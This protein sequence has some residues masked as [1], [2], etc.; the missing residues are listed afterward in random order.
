MSDTATT[1]HFS[2]VDLNGDRADLQASYYMGPHFVGPAGWTESGYRYIHAHQFYQARIALDGGIQ[3]ILITPDRSPDQLGGL[4][5]DWRIGFHSTDTETGSLLFDR[6]H[7]AFGEALAVPQE[8]DAYVHLNGQTTTLLVRASTVPVERDGQTIHALKVEALGADGQP[9]AVDSPLMEELLRNGIGVEYREDTTP[10]PHDIS[11]RMGVAVSGDGVNYTGAVE[12]QAG[13]V[14]AIFRDSATAPI[15]V[16]FDGDSIL[17]EFFQGDRLNTDFG[18]PEA[19][20]FSVLI[21][22]EQSVTVTQVSQSGRGLLLKTAA[23][24]DAGS[25]VQVIYSDDQGDQVFG[26]L[27]T[28]IGND[29]PSSSWTATH[30]PNALRLVPNLVTGTAASE[31]L[32]GTDGNDRIAPAGGDDTIDGG[33]GFDLVV[34][35]G[36][37]SSAQLVFG[38]AGV[39]LTQG[40]QTYLFSNVEAVAFDDVT[41]AQFDGHSY[42]LFPYGSSYESAKLRA[43]SLGGHLLT[44]GTAAENDFVTDLMITSLVNSVALGASDASDE[45][46]W[47]WDTGELV[48]YN[49][50]GPGQPDDAGGDQDFASMI[51]GGSLQG[52]EDRSGWDDRGWGG[53]LLIEVGSHQLITG[54]ISG[55]DGPD[56]L[57]LPNGGSIAQGL[58]GDDQITGGDGPDL[59]YGDAGNDALSGGLGDDTLHGGLDADSLDGG[60]GQD[61]LRGGDG[62]DQVAGGSGHDRIWGDGGADSLLGGDGDDWIDAGPGQDSVDAG[63]GNDAVLIGGDRDGE[64]DTADGGE[65]YD[66]A[67]YDYG[68]STQGVTFKVS[69]TNQQ[70]DPAGGIDTLLNFEERK[71]WGTQHGDSL[72]GSIRRDNLHGRDGDDTI[73]GLGGNDYISGDG[74]SDSLSGGDGDDFITAGRQ[75]DSGNDTVDGGAG[76][77][78]VEY[79]YWGWSTP[80]DFVSNWNASGNFTQ[81]DPGGGVDTLTGIEEVQVV[82]SVVNDLIVGDA[83]RNRIMGNMGDDTLTGG[84]GED[85]FGYSLGFDRGMDVITD[86][87]YGD[88]IRLWDG[89]LFS[90]A[91][92][93]SAGDLGLGQAV[94]SF[95]DAGVLISFGVDEQPGADL[96]I[97]LDR[98]AAED[99]TVHLRQDWNHTVITVE[100]N[101]YQAPIFEFNYHGDRFTVELSGLVGYTLSSQ[102][103]SRFLTAA[104]VFKSSS[105]GDAQLRVIDLETGTVLAGRALTPGEFLVPSSDADTL[106]HVGQVNGSTLRIDSYDYG[107]AASDASLLAAPLKTVTLSLPT[108]AA[109]F[110]IDQYIPPQDVD[111]AGFLSARNTQLPGSGRSLFRIDASGQTTLLENPPDAS[112]AWIGNAFVLNEELWVSAHQKNQDSYYRLTADGWVLITDHD[113]FWDA[114]DFAIQIKSVV[115]DGAGALDLIALLPKGQVA[116]V[117][118]EDRVERLPDG[119]LL[120]RVKAYGYGPGGVEYELWAVK[121]GDDV[122]YKDFT[123]GPGGWGLLRS[124]RDFEPEFVYFQQLNLTFDE[125]GLPVQPD[126]ALT[127]HRIAVSDIKSALMDASDET[128]LS[129]LADAKGVALLMTVMRSSFLIEA[130]LTFLSG[131]FSPSLFEM[132][133]AGALVFFGDYDAT[134]DEATYVINRIDSEGNVTLATVVPDG[135]FEDVVVD[136][137]HGLFFR[138][139]PTDEIEALAYH[140]NPVS[141]VLS[142][143]SVPLFEAIAAAGGIPSDVSFLSGTDANDARGDP[144]AAGTTPQWIAG[145]GGSDTLAGGRGDDL[146]HGGPGHDL[147]DGGKGNDTLVGNAGDDTLRG[148]LGNDRL[149]GDSGS[150]L[151]DGGEQRR[152][153]WL[154]GTA[155]DNDRLEYGDTE[156]IFVNLYTRTV[157][158]TGEQGTDTYS[159]I[160]EITGAFNRRDTIIGRLTN[161]VADVEFGSSLYL[162]LQGGSDTVVQDGYGYQQNWADGV[163]VDYYWSQTGID[164]DYVGDSATV[165]YGASGAQLSGQDTL[166]RV[167]IIG[168]TAH[169]DH[170]NLSEATINHRGHVVDPVMGSSWHALLLGR[171]GNDTVVGNDWTFLHFGS[172]DHTH[173]G[174]GLWLDL[175]EGMADLSNLSTNGI[176]LGTVTFSGVRGTIG[177]RFDDT[178]IGG[179]A[180]N[181]SFESFRGDGGDDFIDGGSGFD[182]ASY[183]WSADGVNVQ[184]AAGIVSSTSSGSDTLRSIENVQGSMFA[185]VYDARG[186]WGGGTSTTANVGSFGSGFNEFQPEGGDDLIHGN[187]RTRLDYDSVMVAVRVDLREGVADARLEADKVTEAYLTMG[188]DAFHGVNEVHGTAYDDL[189]LGGDL[190]NG[191]FITDGYEGFR[192]NAGHDTIDGGTGFDTAYYDNSPAAVQVTLGGL[193]DGLAYD[194][195]GFVDVLREIQEVVGSHFADR[196]NGSNDNVFESLEGRGGDD[197]LNGGLGTTRASYI[198]SPAGA[199]V[200]LAAGTAQDG[201]GSTDTLSGIEWVRGSEY[202]DSISGSDAERVEVFEPRGGND[203]VDGRGGIDQIRYNHASSAVQVDLH[204]GTASDGTGS[205]DSLISIENANA[206]RFDD[207]LRG[208]VAANLL[209]G[210]S[211]NDTLEGRSGNDTLHGGDGIDTAVFTGPRSSY[212]L[213]REASGAW[214]VVDNVAERDGTDTLIGVEVA[215][216]SDGLYGLKQDGGVQFA[217]KFFKV[218]PSGTWLADAPADPTPVPTQV[219]LSQVEATAGTIVTLSR[220]GDFQYGFGDDPQGAPFTDTGTPLLARF[221]NANGQPVQPSTFLGHNTSTQSSGLET[222]VSEDFF[223][224]AGV[225]QIEVP[226]G[227]T[228]LQFSV[229]DRFF[230]D[231]HDPDNDFG[232]VIRKAD[233]YSDYSASDL[234]FGTP[235]AD[236]LIGGLGNDS[237]AGGPGDDTLVGNAGDDRFWGGPGSDVLDGG[238]QKRVP[239]QVSTA[240]DYDRLDY[241]GTAGITVDLAARTVSVTEEEGL[242]LFTGIEEIHGAFNGSDTI[243]GR[244]TASVADAAD[245]TA[246]YLYL[247]GGSDT[248]DQTGYGAQQPW[249]D[250]VIVAYHWSTTPINLVYDGDTATV[251]YGA[252]GSQSAGV[253]TLVNVGVV[254]DS[255]KDDRFDFSQAITNQAGYATS[256]YHQASWH[257]VLMGRGGSDTVIG[258]GLTNLHFGAVDRSA[259]GRGVVLDLKLGDADLS[260]LSSGGNPLGTVT[261]TGVRGFTGTRFNDTLIGGNADNNGFESFRGDGGDDFIDGGQGFDRASYRWS[262]DA[263]TVDLA[264]GTVSSVSSGHDTLRSIEQIQGSMFDDWID[265]RGFGDADAMN[266]G[267]FW[268]GFNSILP[269]GGNDTVHGNGATQLD[270]EG[271]MVGVHAD[272]SAGFGDALDPQV[273]SSLQ[274]GTL[275]RVTFSGVYSLRGSSNDDWLVGGGPGR[276][277]SFVGLEVFNGGAGQDTLDGSWGV[278]IANYQ[279]DIAGIEVDLSQGTARDGWGFVDKLIAIEAIGGSHF[280]DVMIGSN[281]PD[282]ESFIGRRGAD[283]IDGGAGPDDIDFGDDEA[284]VFVRLSGWVGDASS[285]L[286]TGYTGSAIDGYGD[287]D[288]FTNIEGVEG[289]EFDDVIHGDDGDNRLD[290]RGGSDFIDGGLG[291]DWVEYNQ[292]MRPVHVN[293]ADGLAYDDGQGRG[294]LQEHPDAAIEQDTLFNIENVQGGYGDDRLM[295]DAGPN[296]LDG[297]HGHDV[298]VGAAGADTLRGGRGDDTLVGGD[299]FD[300]AVFAGK[301]SEY[302]IWTDAVGL[303]HVVDQVADRDGHDVLTGIESLVF[304]DLAVPPPG[305]GPGV[306]GV[307]YHWKSHALLDDVHI[308]MGRPQDVA[309]DPQQLLDLRNMR[310]DG[311]SG[312]LTVDVWAQPTGPASTFQFTVSAAHAQSMSFSSALGD[313]KWGAS[314]GFDGD[315]LIWA[316]V[317]KSL[318]L[319][320]QNPT[321]LGELTIQLPEGTSAAEATFSG[322]RVGDALLPTGPKLVVGPGATA[323]ELGNFFVGGV[324]PGLTVLHASRLADD[325]TSRSG[326]DVMDAYAALKMAF[327]VNPNADPDGNGPALPLQAS[328]YQFIAADVNGSGTVTLSD[329]LAILRM[330]VGAPNATNLEWMFVEEDRDF[331]DEEAGR[332]TLDKDN[333]AWDR[334]VQ[335][336]LPDQSQTNLVG[337]LKGDVNGSW[338]PSGSILKVTDF[339]PDHFISLSQESGAPLDQWGV[340]PS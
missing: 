182:R 226:Q 313:T 213:T 295:G 308:S 207:T 256:A 217:G 79:A 145:G 41:L 251:T 129:T 50:W 90:W 264:A 181:D 14:E 51:L 46:K 138:T 144:D 235:G 243:T 285:S 124:V 184:L 234:L 273:K 314:F 108:N 196:L 156:G 150:D 275:G 316:A 185:D 281:N 248:V 178:L 231:N 65:G 71:V 212:T 233:S 40:D 292:A 190:A 277:G 195:W 225:T 174:K 137:E 106:F 44:I 28:F 62:N 302:E 88:E 117:W 307:V 109:N 298:L 310:F 115:R 169:N 30:D 250:G 279:H 238:E 25:Q 172:V 120:V 111:Q 33:S 16:A 2:G 287:I 154:V 81:E 54:A 260:H 101:M 318:S 123:S 24:L 153:P 112:S 241:G 49:D 191:A 266:V 151:L 55:T 205:T 168:D 36:Q 198:S 317:P 100:E 333:A 34:W 53:N 237:L 52:P 118:D 102:E 176:T 61:S 155:G 263:I 223:V 162:Y 74:G 332:F 206:T 276:Q 128:P 103:V 240:G 27:Q 271:A 337:V 219:L 32:S 289:S 242:D 255:A 157:V 69:E 67:E 165:S 26:V 232:V 214:N 202:A 218:D 246:L 63:A 107:L 336:Q 211:G 143:I 179:L 10:A 339:Q 319:S 11:F 56:S 330:A 204:A 131:Y 293:L 301:K 7:F 119:S 95:D 86:F 160:E 97:R 311:A 113:E 278:D 163:V 267:S 299:G 290:G 161:S 236:S 326:I 244:L 338:Q 9:Q 89:P 58:S 283:S 99:T 5:L 164:L 193:G 329:A 320:L 247:R 188:R 31:V 57:A 84:G 215:Q 149:Y 331:W 201:W 230:S 189:L 8:F 147:L 257:T 146:L 105:T 228:A 159:G 216:F 268:N 6:P 291:V 167:A 262:G 43:D 78:I 170:F 66:V 15:R 29:L 82:G 127:F 60:D 47:T 38:P 288:V 42:H 70:I 203:T 116:H 327:G 87:S 17:I 75:G 136:P 126:E 21:D 93:V 104:A 227:A 208:N 135:D 83:G 197:T 72:T 59:I 274:Y 254:G 35:G 18:P 180:A 166:T 133:E 114:R 110:V 296:E 45:G 322:I 315:E 152:V 98:L 265:V 323:D 13:L 199:V 272:L 96:Q 284:G 139:E 125:D 245:G 294:W 171:G 253:D 210:L 85:T 140:V 132:D 334:A 73:E 94:Y 76:W 141:G 183:R 64:S 80:I 335:I 39:S 324:F 297:L 224:V 286:P 306:G 68:Q 177:T 259:D 148:G 175:R 249:A 192:G 200:D 37:S 282:G 23:P 48:I 194:G 325:G 158:V 3:A 261:Y 121:D 209:E 305:L 22:G 220:R 122:V 77:D 1:P 312:R 300:Q 130:D 221:V 270:F 134:T 258:N 252:S 280:A 222:N 269:E 12:G 4:L 303:V 20:R 328:P 173:D 186:F 142:Q 239:W 92:G 340:Y 229:N 309:E 91:L 187:G 321:R 304:S 19:A